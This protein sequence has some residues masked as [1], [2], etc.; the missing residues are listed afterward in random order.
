MPIIS[1]NNIE[2][3]FGGHVVLSGVSF[4]IEPGDR[5]GLIGVNGS[6][7]TT[8]LRIISGA[9][10]PDRGSIARARNIRIGHLTQ[11][12]NFSD[13]HSLHQAVITAFDDLIGIEK[14]IKQLEAN[15]SG[16]EVVREYAQLHEQFER[17]GGY[18]YRKRAEEVLN[19]L[20][21]RA[22]VFD[23][24]VSGFSGGEK[25]RA[26]LA[27]LLLSKPDVLLLDEATN[28]LDIESTEWL[29]AFLGR[30]PG[31]FV[32]TS[33]DRYFL[34]RVAGRIIELDDRKVQAHKGNYSAYLIQ[35]EEKLKRLTREYTAQQ[36]YIA[37]QEEFIRRNFAA[38]RAQQSHD[39]EKRLA[40]LERIEKPRLHQKDVKLEFQPNSRGGELV[41]RAE[42]LAKSYDGL[43][44]FRNLTFEV[45]RGERIGLGGPNGAGKST[46]LK[47]ILGQEQP[48]AGICR[49]GHNI[50]IGYYSQQRID[51]KPDND[52]LH[53][54]WSVRPTADSTPLRSY[55]GRFLFSG[56]EV[57]KRVGDLSGGEQARVALAKLILC[58]ANLLLLDEPTNHLDIPSRTALED[59]LLDFEGTVLL[60][61]HDRYLLNKVARKVLAIGYGTAKLYN[62]HYTHCEEQI[63]RQFHPPRP[64]PARPAP[65]KPAPAPA[66]DGKSRNRYR[67]GISLEGLEKSIMQFETELE[68]VEWQLGDPE[69]YRYPEKLK[70]LKKQHADVKAKLEQLNAEWNDYVEKLF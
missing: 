60:V 70:R 37:K 35:K 67:P 31:A 41:L 46:L 21:F 12:P 57:F 64:E 34:D 33:H 5:I 26:A 55:L 20:G 6:G 69:I 24:P 39:R 43:E 49:V 52:I 9:L 18:T 19:G 15:L 11:E 36:E 68:D 13:E 42:R 8:I 25:S 16:P 40:R 7:K 51:V 10:Q 56:D 53:E 61:T 66:T 44:L 48:A 27:R 17:G 22:E 1:L 14:R 65:A 47:L 62:A 30:Y 38:Q 32:L 50:D 29:E 4:G 2:K 45:T 54:M 23:R 28:H 3:A 63:H 58:G 59:A